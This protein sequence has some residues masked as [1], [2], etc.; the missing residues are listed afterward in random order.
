ME[1]KD[2]FN[3]L[4]EET[5]NYINK[6]EDL[7]KEFREFFNNYSA[8]NILSMSDD[9][10]NTF[11]KTSQILNDTQIIFTKIASFIYF[12]KR[13]N[14]EL[15]LD[16]LSEVK[17]LQDFIQSYNPFSTDYIITSEETE[18]RDKKQNIIKFEEFKKNV[19]N[20]V[21]SNILTNE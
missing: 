12:A 15:D 14:I 19:K 11:F 20:I 4:I 6:T 2:Y 18:I 7:R 10:L 8:K 9:K 5:K 3:E 1:S 17:G 16:N 21:E 13:L